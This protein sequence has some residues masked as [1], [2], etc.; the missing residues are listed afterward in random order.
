MSINNKLIQFGIGGMILFF[1]SYAL[2][3]GFSSIHVEKEKAEPFYI[4]GKHYHGQ[5][6]K[7][8]FQEL[9][10]SMMELKKNG[11]LAGEFT[12]C[13]WGDPDSDDSLKVMVGVA[14]PTLPEVTDSLVTEKIVLENVLVGSFETHFLGAPSPS[15]VNDKIKETV[16]E[17]GIK[18]EKL[19]IERYLKGNNIITL[20]PITQ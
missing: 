14:S 1:I 11:E 3:G 7:R 2:L 4:K 8:E 17:M 15:R 5:T 20:V 9:V 10:Y 12:I 19:Y 18:T 13:Y 6:N 16:A